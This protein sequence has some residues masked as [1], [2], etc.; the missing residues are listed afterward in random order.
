[1]L[2]FLLAA[3]LIFSVAIF[4]A[5][6]YVW[7]VPEQEAEELLR[8]RL[9]EIRTHA[10]RGVQSQ[11][12]LLRREQRGS[13]A[14]LGD[15]VTWVGVL[16]RLQEIIRQANLK[17]RAADVLG[18][19]LALAAVTF[20]VLTLFGGMLFLRL[21]IALVAGI[22]PLVY[23]LRVRNRRLR[24][25][26]EQLPDAIDLFTRTMR[27]GHNIHSG[28][29]TIA[30]ETSDPVRMEFRKL[31]EELGLGSQVEPALHELG[32]RIPLIDLKFFITSLILQRQTG[33]NMVAVLENLSTLVRERLNMAAKMKAHTA[34]QRF[35]AGLLCALPFV[36]GL[37]F[38]ILKPEYIR[39]LWTDPVGSKFFTYAICSEIV[40]ILIIRKIANVKV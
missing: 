19:S 25:F 34:Q 12:E 6:Y 13:F 35:S 3:G 5:G 37:G 33:A 38:W 8:T 28:L 18:I 7:S 4:G 27:A 1:M 21:L 15:L 40:G 17:Y 39:L 2:L 30:N 11:P 36:V 32:K 14:F 9:R 26:E 24:K 22:V 10:R 31:M 16:R 20:V 29:E 23:I